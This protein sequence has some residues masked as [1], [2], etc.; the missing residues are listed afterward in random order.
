MAPVDEQEPI[1]EVAELDIA[2][3]ENPEAWRVVI[4][5]IP[6]HHTSSALASL[7]SMGVPLNDV[8]DGQMSVY[9]EYGPSSCSIG[10]P[11]EASL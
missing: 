1:P 8:E 2:R 7:V 4:S 9:R 3:G 10:Y 11:E 5:R 6:T